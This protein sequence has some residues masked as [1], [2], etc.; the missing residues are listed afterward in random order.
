[1][2]RLFQRELR[3]RKSITIRSID[4]QEAFLGL[5]FLENSIFSGNYLLFFLVLQEIISVAVFIARIMASY[6]SGIT[7]I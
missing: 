1:M 5:L 4:L 3:M 6:G 2:M 7:D